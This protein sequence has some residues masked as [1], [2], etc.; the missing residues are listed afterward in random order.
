MCLLENDDLDATMNSGSN[1]LT[2]LKTFNVL[3]ILNVKTSFLRK[4]KSVKIMKTRTKWNFF[5]LA[6]EGK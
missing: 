1:G 5:Y 4:G 3:K 2:I 6:V